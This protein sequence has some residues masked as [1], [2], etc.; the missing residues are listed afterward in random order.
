MLSRKEQKNCVAC[1]TLVPSR[2]TGLLS[3]HVDVIS[4]EKTSENFRILYDVK[5]RFIVHRISPEEAKVC[6]NPSHFTLYY[7]YLRTF[8]SL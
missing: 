1:T 4:I 6:G 3:L 5:G 8:S 7:R 2:V